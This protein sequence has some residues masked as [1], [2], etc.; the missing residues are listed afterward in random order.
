MLTIFEEMDGQ[1]VAINSEYIRYIK[2]GEH[3]DC[4]LYMAH[5]PS[6]EKDTFRIKGTLPE[7]ISRILNLK[8]K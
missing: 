7:V 3:N 6:G 4:F 2:A 8:K 1:L 5:T